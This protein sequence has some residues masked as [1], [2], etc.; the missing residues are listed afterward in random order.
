MNNQEINLVQYDA[1]I[2]KLYIRSPRDMLLIG[3]RAE[4]DQKRPGQIDFIGGKREAGDRTPVHTAIREAKE[5]SSMQLSEERLR[6]VGSTSC[7][8]ASRGTESIIRYYET[9]VPEWC[10]FKPNPDE[11]DDMMFMRIPEILDHLEHAGQRE[12]LQRYADQSMEL[13]LV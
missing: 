13:T 10:Y 4:H 1:E 6:F 9:I 2:S 12:M 5:E 11:F 8:S 7:L 3:V